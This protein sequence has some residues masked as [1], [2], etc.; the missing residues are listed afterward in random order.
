MARLIVDADELVVRL[1]R[2]EKAGA[3]HGDVRVPLAGVQDVAVSAQPFGELRGLRAPGTGLPAVIALGTW[4]YAG[5][6][7]FVALY[8]RRPAVIVG[9]RDARYQRLLVSAEDAGAV[10]AAIRARR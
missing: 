6:R 7:D 10:A 5:G 4:R 1:T 9:L 8:R 2:W 3:L